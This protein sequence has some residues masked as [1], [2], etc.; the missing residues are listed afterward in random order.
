MIARRGFEP[1]TSGQKRLV[2]P[3]VSDSYSFF[4]DPDPAFEAGGQSG[5]GS[6]YNPDP[7]F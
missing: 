5:S 6:G 7:G 1:G 2:V 4:P 3:R